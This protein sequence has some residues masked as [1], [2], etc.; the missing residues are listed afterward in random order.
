MV[1]SAPEERVSNHEAP[2]M[3]PSFE[4]PRLGAAPQDEARESQRSAARIFGQAPGAACNSACASPGKE[5]RA[6]GTPRVGRTQVYAACANEGARAHGPRRLATS[7]LVEVLV[8][9]A[10]PPTQRRPARGVCK[11]CS[12]PSPVVDPSRARERTVR[13][14]P[15]VEALATQPAMLLTARRLTSRQWG[16]RRAAARRDH[17]RLGPPGG[18]YAP[19]LRRPI[20]G[21]RSPPRVWRR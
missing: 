14:L 16:S 20:P 6:R 4:T 8:S 15:P 3:R 17:A 21:H 5:P 11:V 13:D 10:S 7:R 2:V 1:R 9:A 12:A 19:H 18:K